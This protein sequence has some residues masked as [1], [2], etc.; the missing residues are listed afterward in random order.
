MLISE[1]VSISLSL[2]GMM[3][4]QSITNYPIFK[5][6]TEEH[7]KPPVEIEQ[8]QQNVHKKV[9]NPVSATGWVGVGAIATAI[10]SGI[11]HLNKLHKISAFVGVGAIAGHI[12]LVKAHHHAHNK[13]CC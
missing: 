3:K 5:A 13:D 8:I 7:R 4:I 6:V 2:G 12:G 1:C 11:K 9:L 10:I